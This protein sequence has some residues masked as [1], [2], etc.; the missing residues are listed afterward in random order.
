MK[1]GQKYVVQCYKAVACSKIGL[2]ESGKYQVG[3]YVTYEGDPTKKLEKAHIYKH[4]HEFNE[5]WLDDFECDK[6]L[7]KHFK[8]VPV[9]IVSKIT[10]V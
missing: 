1:R 8:C 6:R 7:S 5:F 10:K 9:K 4:G 3:D 2:G